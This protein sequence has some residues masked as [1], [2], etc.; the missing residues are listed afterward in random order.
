VI[1]S[2]T[3]HHAAAVVLHTDTGNIAFISAYLPD[4]WKPGPVFY[5]A[6]EQMQRLL[7]QI[8]ASCGLGTAFVLGGDLN[9][10]LA[11]CA[12]VGPAVTGSQTNDRAAALLCFAVANNLVWSSTQNTD[13]EYWTFM[14]KS[15]VFPRKMVLDYVLTSPRICAA[16]HVRYDIDYNCDHRA[17]DT[18]IS[19]PGKTRITY[20][21]RRA[22]FKNPH[23]QAFVAH[24]V[25]AAAYGEQFKDVAEFQTFL[26]AVC[27]A[28]PVYQK[29]KQDMP[30]A[31]KNSFAALRD[32]EG[33]SE[34]KVRLARQT[35][36]ARRNWWDEQQ[37]ASAP[38][39]L[40]KLCRKSAGKD[41]SSRK[42]A[43]LKIG[44]IPSSDPGVWATEI[45][46]HYAKQYHDDSIRGGVVDET[47]RRELLRLQ[48]ERLLTLRAKA[49]GEPHLHIPLWLVLEAKS[50]FCAKPPT[51]PGIDMVCWSMLSLLPDRFWE[52]VRRVFEDRLNDCW[53]AAS[54]PDWQTVLVTL[55]P[56]AGDISLLQNWRPISL[57]P[58]FQK[59]FMSC[60]NGVMDLTAAPL[61]MS[62][63][64]FRAGHQPMEA[65]ESLRLILQKTYSW[66]EPVII[67][68]FDV[69]KAFD[70]LAH[71]KIVETLTYHH[72]PAKIIG[73]LLNELVGCEMR[74][75]LQ[76]TT[77]SSS[78]LLCSGGKQG[79]SETPGVWNRY[80]D[81]AWQKACKIFATKHLGLEMRTP[82]WKPEYFHGVFWADDIYLVAC[83]WE[84]I[85]T[86]FGIL[87]SEIASLGLRWKESV[88]EMLLNPYVEGF[89]NLARVDMPTV[90][91]NISFKLVEKLVVLG[92]SLDS[93]GTY[94][95][96]IRH[97]MSCV[98]ASW[99]HLAPYFQA[100]RVPLLTRFKKFY[101]ICGR[102]FLYGAGGWVLDT[103]LQAMIDKFESKFT[104]KILCRVPQP[105]ELHR[106]FET[107]M[108]L[109]VR[110][111]RDRS[112]LAPLSLQAQVCYYGW[113]G[114]IAR[115]HKDELIRA[116]LR[117][118]PLE[119]FRRV[120]ALG[121]D[122]SGQRVSMMRVG[123]PVRWESDLI[124]MCGD[125]WEIQALDRQPWA[126]QKLA[127]ARSK[128]L[129]SHRPCGFHTHMKDFVCLSHISP[130]VQSVV[131]AS[132]TLRDIAFI[133]CV[134]NQQV[135]EQISGSWPVD[136]GSRW[137]GVVRQCRW[138][139]H[140]L[141]TS[142]APSRWCRSLPW[143]RH[144]RREENSVADACA[145]L[146][147][148]R[149][150]FSWRSNYKLD[151]SD[152]L[153]L[154][155]DAAF[156]NGEAGLGTCVHAFCRSSG[157]VRV[158]WAAG[159]R[160]QCLDN[161]EAEFEAFE[162]GLRSFLH[163][164]QLCV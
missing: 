115:M 33:P 35:Y 1:F 139:L 137:F 138:L 90:F 155:T 156:N 51:A 124:E 110:D 27:N 71:D 12:H 150:Q 86:M 64:G 140:V 23:T 30:S 143:V 79:A 128:W 92:T 133:A 154:C 126:E 16:H 159:L 99:S 4:A 10:E 38:A 118:R 55:I 161:V 80:I 149:G 24:A 11:S 93:R 123:R 127:K 103:E 153:M 17:I 84:H 44:D 25:E 74:V 78:P 109:L 111:L 147:R 96:S 98:W 117:W 67:I 82:P 100:R 131:H 119:W 76:G 148:L 75:S 59:L 49:L 151:R 7:Q 29:P 15:A 72:V 121:M 42:T 106:D 108:N 66:K 43:S 47:R 28:A 135:A 160:A 13:M 60:V 134:D 22:D 88:C 136:T 102:C 41:K 114:H 54:V 146:G 145:E 95:T 70:N 157:T 52:S 37:K 58:I 34:E 141:T 87:S 107:R 101:E 97:R 39:R 63:I 89:E 125:D 144:H 91:G 112:C 129:Q 45:S 53:S 50:R 48:K 116:V 20:V 77:C 163:W 158:V 3:S 26:K 18:T 57:S 8:R 152:A 31:L 32:F 9:V 132:G 68:K 81:T 85:K 2:H 5:N 21:A 40:L 6:L 14:H 46:N 104:R 113:G 61:S 65:S 36:R 83:S 62:C 69:S 164:C 94:S 120:R 130:R 122:D 162:W 56:K 105:G 142:L 19:L 73:C